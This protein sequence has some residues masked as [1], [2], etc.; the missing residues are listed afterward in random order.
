MPNHVAFMATEN[1]LSL[2]DLLSHIPFERRKRSITSTRELGM[3]LFEILRGIEK[4]REE[5]VYENDGER[6]RSGHGSGL[7]REKGTYIYMKPSKNSSR[8]DL[9]FLGKIKKEL[10]KKRKFEEGTPEVKILLDA[11]R[12][13]SELLFEIE[14]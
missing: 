7:K 14:D 5:R 8:R 13:A 4:E 9:I 1:K 6:E 12:R 2:G 10:G 11:I 3:K